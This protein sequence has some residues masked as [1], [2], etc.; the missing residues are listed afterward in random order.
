MQQIISKLIYN[1]SANWHFGKPWYMNDFWLVVSVKRSKNWQKMHKITHNAMKNRGSTPVL[2][3]LVGVQTRNIHRKF[4][5]KL[6][7]GLKRSKNTS[8]IHSRWKT[9]IAVATCKSLY[10]AVASLKMFA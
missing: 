4:E 1:T 2:T 5:A 3:N 8:E 7:S 9:V 10:I 6:C